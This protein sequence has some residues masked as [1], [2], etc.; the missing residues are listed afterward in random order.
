[1]RAAR[2]RP[3]RH[4][5]APEVVQT[6]AMDCGPA[7]LTCLLAG[8]G[9]SV[10]YGRLREACQTDVDGTSIDMLETIAVQLGLHAE[11]ILVPVDH[12]FLPETRALPAI[13]VVQL[14][15]GVTHFVVAWRR[16]GRVVQVMDPG[17]GRRWPT[18]RRFLDELYVHTQSVPATAWRA[19]AETD[20]FLGGLRRRW[21]TLA[22]GGAEGERL[23]AEVLADPTWVPLAA[24]D[25][26][27]R[28][29]TALVHGKG[30]R[31]GQQATRA[32]A[33]FFARASQEDPTMP[34]TVPA[35]YWM[36]RPAPPD[37]DGTP[38]LLV[39][40]AVLVRVCGE[41]AS[42]STTVVEDTAPSQDTPTPLPPDL[43]AALEAPPSRP[44]RHLLRLLR[45]DGLLTPTTLGLGVCLAAGSV[46]VEA[47]LWRGLVDLHRHLGSGEQRLGALGALLVFVSALLLLDLGNALGLG[48]LGRRLEARLRMAFLEKIPR[49]GDRYFQS[50]PAS[51]M[52]ERSH[53]V[54]RLRLLP[55]L[56]GQLI[57]VAIE[58]GMTT[59]GLVWL[60]PSQALLAVLAAVGTQV[61]PLAMHPLL[62]ERDLR[63]RTHAGA[64][65]R[66]SLDALLGLT[67]IR[68][69]GAEQAMHREHE[70][71]LVEWTRAG[72]HLQR[73]VVSVEGVQG[74]LGF[75]LAAGL[76]AAYLARGGEASGALLLTY[77]ALRLPALGQELMLLAWQYP[78]Q[79]NI[80][81][82][83]LE[84]LGAREEGDAGAH[85]Q[86]AGQASA[87]PSASGQG[88]AIALEGVS[89]R[90]AGHTI[91]T[92]LTLALAPGS[93]V[94]IVGPS[95]AGKSSLVGLLLGWHRPATGQVLV[96]GRPLD[97]QHLAWVRQRTAWVDPAIQLWN[98]PL[99]DN[100][101]YGV[102]DAPASLAALAL[103][104]A[105]LRGVLDRLPDGL[106]TPLGEGGGLVS[107]GE[108]QRVRF[109]R[110]LARRGVRLVILDEPFRGLDREQRR[111]LLQRARQVWSTATLLCITHDVEVTQTFDRVVV[112]EGGRIIEDGTPARLASCPE[113]RYRAL[114]D[115]EI[116][117]H[118]GL[119]SS[120]L[121]RRLQ[122]VEGRVR[123]EGA[124][125]PRL[126]VPGTA[127]KE[128]SRWKPSTPWPGQSDASVRP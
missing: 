44:G 115:A 67:A 78:G 29:L 57:H 64:L 122:L 20:A 79:R 48:R 72:L 70:S 42:S 6:S 16:H 87:P 118:E 114:L 7:A 84:P 100:L 80:T 36:V 15:N 58:L 94:A 109:G 51:D 30:L 89:V 4:L 121:W 9:L 108:G 116:A 1:M 113:T 46:V 17:T 98:R 83:L 68:T 25:A 104:Q 18:C 119:W 8:Y 76:L 55:H 127:R 111:I 14:P 75:G 11:Q 40:G 81:L 3:R 86:S 91:L 65:S 50:R 105:D 77:W 33:T 61:L 93:H 103:A 2:P 112:V 85:E 56:G 38:S 96:E 60:A 27:T 62:T 32:L 54:H 97:D 128:A 102:A 95:G 69:H 22:I 21:A 101:C 92:D 66:F 82:R 117:V 5:F 59:A 24:L 34:S 90:A 99:L 63:V 53:S 107:G 120:G 47:L 35:A 28:L 37:P 125:N 23:L 49:L 26:T 19:W 123:E 45:A 31:R 110:A 41:Q 73:A 10:S 43:V 74:L 12:L 126:V 71:L 88:I 13:V 52:A 39:R 106:Q 124:F